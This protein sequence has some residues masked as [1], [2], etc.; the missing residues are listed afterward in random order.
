MDLKLAK[1][2]AKLKI[3]SYGRL[4]VITYLYPDLSYISSKFLKCRG[5]LQIFS[6]AM[7]T[8]VAMCDCTY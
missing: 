4:Y 6:R 2:F 3:T 5:E 7:I 1:I 8:E